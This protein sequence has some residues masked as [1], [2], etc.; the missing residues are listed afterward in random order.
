MSLDLTSFT[1][2]L[3]RAPYVL[4]AVIEGRSDEWLDRKHAE[5]VMSPR[6]AVAHLLLCEKYGSWIDRISIAK[7][8]DYKPDYEKLNTN[9]LLECHSISDLLDIF[10]VQR[11][12]NVV[13]LPKVVQTEADFNARSTHRDDSSESVS[14]LLNTWVA[15][16]LYHL[17]QIFKSFSA[18]YIG[19][20]GHY[21]GYLNLPHFN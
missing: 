19:K 3:S 2:P 1:E 8:P 15:H 4:R 6:R 11:A 17:G 12:L 16:D 20:I 18:P 13:E 7:N 10:A 14:E 5:D 9:A 21:Q